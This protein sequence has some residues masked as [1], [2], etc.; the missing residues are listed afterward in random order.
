MI[1]TG[2]QAAF[3]LLS[4]LLLDPGDQ[5]WMEEPGYF[6]AAFSVAGGDLHALQVDEFRWN[7]Q[8]PGGLKPR[9]I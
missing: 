3:D 6:G 8:L 1:T 9:I 7:F 5:V 2:A 4:R